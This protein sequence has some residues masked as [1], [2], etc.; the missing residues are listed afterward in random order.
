MPI[1]EPAALLREARSQAGLTQR[2][3]AR[4]A[5]TAQSVV[6]RI[7][8]GATSPSWETLARLLEAAGFALDVALRPLTPELSHM[9]DDVPRILRL[10]PEQ[11][12]VELR[13]TSRLLTAARRRA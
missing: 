4:R 10:T 9:L 5:G 12:L 3:L 1:P 2:E 7:E 11:R 6:A 8:G 13:N